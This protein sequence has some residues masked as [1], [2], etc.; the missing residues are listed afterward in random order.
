MASIDNS[1]PVA[2][3]Y[4]LKQILINK[5]VSNEW[6][7]GD[8]IPTELEL[9]KQYELSRITVRQA[10]S[11]LVNEGYLIRKQ[12]KGTFVSLPRMEQNLMSFYSFT[13][14]FRKRGYKVHNKVL[15]FKVLPA[16]EKIQKKLNLDT[17][18]KDVYYFIRLRYANDVVIAMESTYLPFHC[19]PDL[20]K[21]DIESHALYDIMRNK[22]G[23]IPDSA[24]EIFG[25]TM[26]QTE[27]AKYFE[28]KKG[29]PALEIERVTYG[30]EKDIIEYTEGV[31]RGDKFKF[32]IYLK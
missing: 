15:D 23:I 18:Q 27:Q 28:L 32:H 5:I 25:A 1:V 7:P 24:E 9:C 10:L 22:Y 6:K 4:Q 14:E 20:T 13:E 12:G 29:L 30:K 3:Y 19:F 2:L 17:P 11:E 21:E 26:L 31:I 16:D 8:K